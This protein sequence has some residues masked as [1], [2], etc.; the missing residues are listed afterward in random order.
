M[1]SNRNG[2]EDPGAA[3]YMGERSSL[4]KSKTLDP[5]L[6]S[7]AQETTS[8]SGGFQSYEDDQFTSASFSRQSSTNVT[9]R[10]PSTSSVLTSRKINSAQ[11]SDFS[12]AKNAEDEAWDL[13]KD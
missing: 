7:S 6:L 2:Y 9:E 11:V 1:V 5:S 13:L 8:Y 10:T 12:K 4:V 3:G